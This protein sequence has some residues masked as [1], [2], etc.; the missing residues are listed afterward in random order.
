MFPAIFLDRDGV[1]IENVD[2]YVRSWADVA[3]YP[4]TFAALSRLKNSP[5][6][7]VVVTNQSL[8]GRGIISAEEAAGINN[9]LVA[10]VR[11]SGGQ[12]DAVF[13]CP[14]A[15]SA[16]CDCRKPRPG[17]ILQACT[18]LSLDLSRSVM[19]GDAL[20]DIGA[21]QNAGIPLNILLSTGRGEAQR[22]LPEAQ[23]MKPFHTC[24]S[25]D[26]AVDA[27]LSGLLSNKIK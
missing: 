21:G 6:K 1:L 4:W 26:D 13:M 23:S 20:S 19:I 16:Y 22:K 18:Q 3:V 24:A 9:R 11:D 8:V 5:Y 27:L 12:I 2:T 25:L 7:I 17:L 10:A 15:P 14:H